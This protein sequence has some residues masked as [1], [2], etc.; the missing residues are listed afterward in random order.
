MRLRNWLAHPMTRGID[1]DDPQTT[2]LRRQI[3]ME[4]PLLYSIYEQWYRVILN[5]LP[6]GI[7]PVLE[8]GTGAGFLK[9]FCPELVTSDIFWLPDN[10]LTLDGQRIP[11]TAASL[12]GIVMIN[13]LH[14]VPQTRLFFKEAVRCLRPGGV[15]AMIEP[16]LTKWS[17]LVYKSLHSEPCEPDQPA[18]EFSSTGPLSAANEALPWIIFQRDRGQFESE[19]PSLKIKTLQPF[20]PFQYLLS[21][22][23]SMRNLTPYWSAGLLQAFE[24]A[25]QP[26]MGHLAMFAAI[27][28]ENNP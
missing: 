18:W 28:L 17:G 7:G 25:L 26:W 5:S 12:R 24:K 1:V 10:T 6:K 22:G 14:H 2:L 3:I 4:K 23:V 11:F 19:F 15:L 21:G 27:T 9:Q 20:M 13:V 16:W 8:L